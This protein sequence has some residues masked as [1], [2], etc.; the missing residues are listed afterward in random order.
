MD[1]GCG[2]ITEVLALSR[3]EIQCA[4]LWAGLRRHSDIDTAG[5]SG[6]LF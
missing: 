1:S 6:G 4:R 5:S 2:E 3:G